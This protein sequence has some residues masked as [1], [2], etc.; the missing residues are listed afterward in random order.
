MKRKINYFF[1]AALTLLSSACATRYGEAGFFSN[2]YTDFRY[3]EDTFDVSFRANEYTK[4]D[5]VMK[6]ALLRASELTLKHGYN[7]FTV[8]EQS[9]TTRSALQF[10]THQSWSTTHGSVSQLHYPSL[11]LKIKCFAEKPASG[12]IVDAKE[13]LSY[14]SEK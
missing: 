9:D 7:Y 14:N 3:S 12:D 6:Y 13:F 4:S 11:R 1:L 8:L 5:K 2:G 10:N